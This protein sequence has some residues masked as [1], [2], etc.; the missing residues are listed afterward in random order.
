MPEAMNIQEQHNLGEGNLDS[1]ERDE[2][3]EINEGDGQNVHAHPVNIDQEVVV[4]RQRIGNA[5]NSNNRP[6]QSQRRVEDIQRNQDMEQRR[7]MQ[8]PVQGNAQGNGNQGIPEEARF[9]AGQG[10]QGVA[11]GHG[12]M[13]RGA[14][15][16][17][18]FVRGNMSGHV[19]DG[20]Y[21]R[22][23]PQQG[24]VQYQPYN[25]PRNRQPEWSRGQS[26]FDM[27]PR[28]Q[29]YISERL[30]SQ[31]NGINN[32]RQEHKEAQPHYNA[33][34]AARLHQ[35]SGFHSGGFMYPTALDGPFARAMSQITC[36][37]TTA[38]QGIF[39]NHSNL[40][41]DLFEQLQMALTIKMGLNGP[42]QVKERALHNVLTNSPARTDM[43]Q[44]LQSRAE[45][46]GDELDPK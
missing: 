44:I 9:Q 12:R 13:M 25:D 29:Q 15:G 17:G 5:Q 14:R 46:Y 34:D 26:L 39:E 20:G 37:P 41:K 10:V 11:R 32:G 24:G 28:D 43:R 30:A 21:G 22:N 16:G 6:P 35:Q 4:Q 8:G 3:G 1:R 38:N 27:V 33:G 45:L 18:G 36:N 23:M 2:F 31:S 19:N 7:G 40:N 42:Q